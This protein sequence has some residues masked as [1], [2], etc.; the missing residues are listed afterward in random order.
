[1]TYTFSCPWPCVREIVVEAGDVDDAV[2]KIIR[3]G[4]MTC[5]NGATRKA[6]E[7]THPPMSPLPDGQ[8]RDVV[9]LIM[10]EEDPSELRDG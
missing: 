2:R 7:G 6:C 5:R 10:K 9:R 4:G 3:A 8:L 1:M